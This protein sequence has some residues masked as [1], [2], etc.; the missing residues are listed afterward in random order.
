MRTPSVNDLSL[1]PA[2][3]VRAY[4]EKLLEDFIR[5]HPATFLNETMQLVMQQP[6]IGGFRP[7]LIFR[8]AGGRLVI[9]E[10]QLRALDRS[11]LYR[12]LE[13]RDLL[14][15]ETQC[16]EP[17]IILFCNDLRPRHERLLAIHRLSCV[18]VSKESFLAK[19]RLLQPSLEVTDAVDDDEEHALT[20]RKVLKA[21]Q[22]PALPIEDRQDPDARVFWF[23]PGFPHDGHQWK[24]DIW[25]RLPIPDLTAA[26]PLFFNNGTD[27]RDQLPAEVI[28]DRQ[29]TESIDIEQLRMIREW[30][31]LLET[32]HDYGGGNTELVL[33][34]RGCSPNPECRSIDFSS[35]RVYQYERYIQG[36]IR[37]FEPIWA[38]YGESRGYDVARIR[39][40]LALF[41][42]FTFY[43]GKYPTLTPVPPC[44]V[45]EVKLGP[46]SL[47]SAVEERRSLIQYWIGA[48]T[49][50]Y[51]AKTLEEFDH[52]VREDQDEWVTVRFKGL[53]DVVLMCLDVLT[54]S[55]LN[56][57]WDAKTSNVRRLLNRIGLQP[58]R[59]LRDIAP[60]ALRLSARYFFH[61]KRPDEGIV[62]VPQD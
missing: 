35:D 39:S 37:R 28:V 52:H 30:L 22:N 13:Y 50:G 21:L 2:R 42:S 16:E 23:G 45:F 12:T 59:G 10:V 1:N 11:H 19:A 15:H 62:R 58:S 7:D 43:A 8:D 41:Q 40:D 24:P 29:A 20:A 31:D 27:F 54:Q 32:N 26:A 47:L 33:G 61:L 18:T 60:E 14:M 48:H 3:H 34:Y 57:E 55:L 36:R 44:T 4:E 38:R 46:G 25:Q 51:S 9:V 56:A 53:S 49:P 5:D 6:T 17:R